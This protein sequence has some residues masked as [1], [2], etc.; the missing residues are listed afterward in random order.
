MA[1]ARLLDP[2][3]AYQRRAIATIKILLKEFDSGPC[4]GKKYN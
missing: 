1:I 4:S 2:R 3:W